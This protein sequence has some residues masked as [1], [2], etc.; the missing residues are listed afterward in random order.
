MRARGQRSI[1]AAIVGD[2]GRAFSDRFQTDD[3]W[4]EGRQIAQSQAGPR[5]A[6][7]AP[8]LEMLCRSG[9]NVH[10]MTTKKQA[11]RETCDDQQT[12][13]VLQMWTDLIHGRNPVNP[14]ASQSIQ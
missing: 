4:D 14:P 6:H 11:D 1:I 10:R 3:R 7:F 9:R 5:P 12:T 2:L 13:T 8:A